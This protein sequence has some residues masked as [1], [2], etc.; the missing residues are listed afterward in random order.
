[1]I[2]TARET[3]KRYTNTPIVANNSLMHWSKTAACIVTAATPGGFCLTKDIRERLGAQ[4]I[5]GIAEEHAGLTLLAG[6]A[7]PTVAR[8]FYRFTAHFLQR[9]S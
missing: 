8:R 9:V 4:Y 6:I 3:K 1:M 2:L 5:D 7:W